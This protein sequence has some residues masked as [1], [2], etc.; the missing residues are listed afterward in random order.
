MTRETITLTQVEQRRVIVLTQVREQRIDAARAAALLGLSLRH[1][2]RLLAAF[3][4]EGPATVARGLPLAFAALSAPI[5]P[6]ASRSLPAD[7]PLRSPSSRP[8]TRMPTAQLRS[9][10]AHLPA[11]GAR[12]TPQR[13]RSGAGAGEGSGAA[14]HRP[15]P[16]QSSQRIRCI[17]PTLMLYSSRG[18]SLLN[19]LDWAD[20]VD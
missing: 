19:W 11:A 17:H 4:R 18:P 13:R 3:R 6:Q 2:R 16:Y 8:A 7:C 12:I 9:R 10:G 14:L 5:Y 1:C 20:W 15:R